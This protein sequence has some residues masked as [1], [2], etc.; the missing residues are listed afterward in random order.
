M[1]HYL[2]NSETNQVLG[3]S[4][5]EYIVEL[6]LL[7]IARVN[8][9]E[10]LTNIHEYCRLIYDPDEEDIRDKT[11][12]EI[13]HCMTQYKRDIIDENTDEIIAN[14]TFIYH[15]NHFKLDSEH[16]SSFTGIYNIKHL[17]TYPYKLKGV[18][19]H[20][21]QAENSQDVE[22]FY[23]TGL[24]ALETIFQ[25]GWYLKYTLLPSLTLEELEVWE[26]PRV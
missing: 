26:D 21:Y 6:P 8:D 20:F 12:D 16:Q 9:Y 3:D 25:Y 2:V 4:K 15:D 23:V 11:D 17:L 19:D 10:G 18:G 14:G 22:N 24:I 13:Y 5:N 1:I 7:D